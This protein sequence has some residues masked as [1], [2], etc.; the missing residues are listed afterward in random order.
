MKAIFYFSARTIPHLP[1]QCSKNLQLLATIVLAKS[2][3]LWPLKDFFNGLIPQLIQSL[4]LV[5]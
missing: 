5:I 1:K 2:N 4:K 3:N